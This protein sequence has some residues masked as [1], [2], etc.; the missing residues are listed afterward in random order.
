MAKK[1]RN[2]KSGTSDSLSK[3]QS[4]GRTLARRRKSARSNNRGN[5]QQPS[6]SNQNFSRR[7]KMRSA[8]ENSSRRRSRALL[9]DL[10]RGEAPYV[11]LLRKYHLDT[12]TARKH[13]GAALHIGPGGRV[14]ASKSDRLTREL[15]FPLSSGDVPTRIRGSK[16]ATK[17]SEFFNDRE[18]LLRNKMSAEQFEAKWRGVRIAGQEV[19]A[20]SATIFLR[21]DAGDLKVDHLYSSV[22]GGE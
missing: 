9:H 19:F 14:H 10:R 15:L 18:K 12:R 21:A 22:G 2:N 13:L 20:D 16:A 4:T 1:F 6:F 11:E 3:K 8:R 7:P 5:N 17:L